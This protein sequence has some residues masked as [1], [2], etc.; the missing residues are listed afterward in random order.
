MENNKN[1]NILTDEQRAIIDVPTPKEMLSQNPKQPYLTSVK[2]YYVIEIL[3]KAFGEFGWEFDAAVDEK[4]ADFIVVKGM[5]KIKLENDKFHTINQFGG[6]DSK[7]RGDAHKGACTDALK[8]CASYL[9]ICADVFRG[10]VKPIDD[11]S[12]ITMNNK[13]LKTEDPKQKDFSSKPNLPITE[14]MNKIVPFKKGSNV[15]KTWAEVDDK[16][17]LYVIESFDDGQI[18]DLA[19]EERNRRMTDDSEVN[20]NIG[21]DEIPA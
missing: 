13:N 17:L 9:G 18:K 2:A 21:L 3:N 16:T 12:A 7:I 1:F 10:D 6:H 20:N 4:M 19:F 11:Y 8:K 15:G 14:N 5:L